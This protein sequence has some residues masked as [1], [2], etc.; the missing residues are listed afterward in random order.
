MSSNVVNNQP[1]IRTTWDLADT[2]IKDLVREL[3]RDYIEIAN[4]INYRTIGIFPTNRPAIGGESWFFTSKR[5]QNIR[6]I[7]TFEGPIAA[8]PFEIPH[9]LDLYTI[10]YFTKCQG[11][12]QTTSLN[13]IGCIYGSGNAIPGQITFA[14]ITNSAPGVLDG[15]IRLLNAPATPVVKKGVIILEWILN[16]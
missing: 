7:Y 12:I 15:K 3:D 13:W 2:N 9:N 14:V 5:Q 1:Y 10:E 4:A 11:S 6:Q 16:P 8:Y